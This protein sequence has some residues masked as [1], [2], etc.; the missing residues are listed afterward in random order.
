M[1]PTDRVQNGIELRCACFGFD[2]NLFGPDF[3]YFINWA[4]YRNNGKQNVIGNAADGTAL[5][6]KVIG[7]V[8]PADR[9]PARA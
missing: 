3:Q 5:N 9:R 2:G 7:T 4:T 1:K 8:R 6:G